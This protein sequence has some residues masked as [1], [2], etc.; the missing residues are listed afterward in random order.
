[1][2]LNITWQPLQPLT[3]EWKVFAHLIDS[4]HH[5]IA[6]FDGPPQQGTYP[7]S[8][9]IPGELIKDSYPLTLPANTPP[10]PY[11]VYLG[12]YNEATGAR[13]PVPGDAE[14]RVILDVK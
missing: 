8:Q 5:V 7:T 11:Q 2:Y 3:E 14:G 9:W 4:N 10:G 1:L 6:Q 12:L 13:L